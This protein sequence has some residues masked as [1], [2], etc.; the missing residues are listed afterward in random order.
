VGKVKIIVVCALFVLL[1]STG[2]Q[3]GACEIANYELQDDLK[4]I[5]SLNSWR[6]GLAAPKSDDDLREAV[7]SRAREHGIV[8]DPRQVTVRRSGSSE[9]PVVYLAVDYKAHITLP[10]YTFTLRFKPRGG[11]RL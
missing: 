10:G 4:D 7:I 9:T 2:W 3:I 5:A 6:I 8:L 1:A 11:R